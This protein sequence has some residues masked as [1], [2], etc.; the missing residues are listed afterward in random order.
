M[1][2]PQEALNITPASGI[3]NLTTLQE[4]KE[5]ASTRLKTIEVPKSGKRNYKKYISGTKIINPHWKYA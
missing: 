3:R 2:Q 5:E 1:L 4:Y